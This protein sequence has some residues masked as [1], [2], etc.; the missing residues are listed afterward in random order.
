[1]GNE[2]ASAN[3]A[4]YTPAMSYYSGAS[5]TIHHSAELRLRTALLE[6][7]ALLEVCVNTHLGN[8]PPPIAQELGR[9]RKRERQLMVEQ[10]QTAAQLQAAQR[11][12]QETQQ[13]H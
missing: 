6:K 12:E 5:P 8:A 7:Q 9:V 2:N 11:R 3:S 13:V 10:K 1:M 4:T